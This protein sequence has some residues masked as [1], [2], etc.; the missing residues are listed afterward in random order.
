M[1]AAVP[2]CDNL[3]ISVRRPSNGLERHPNI[4]SRDGTTSCNGGAATCAYATNN[5]PMGTHAIL[6]P[7][8][9]LHTDNCTQT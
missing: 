3:I 1:V 2:T 9:E 5:L 4:F 8:C 7:A 6:L